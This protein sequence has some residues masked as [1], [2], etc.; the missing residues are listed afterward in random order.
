MQPIQLI[1]L[2]HSAF[3]T[4]FLMT[5]VA[6]FLSQ[7]GLSANYRCASSVEELETALLEGTADVAQSAVGVSMRQ[8]DKNPTV[9][10]PI[11]HFAQI[12]QRDGF[13][14]AAAV[15]SHAEFSWKGLENKRIIAD[16]LFQPMATLKYVLNQRGVDVSKIAFINAGDIE[17]SQAA[18]LDGKAEFIHLQGPYPQQ[19]MANGKAIIVASVG[20]ALGNIAYSSLCATKTW[21][22]SPM[23]TKFIHA[24]KAALA[25]VQQ[26]DASQLA[27]Q[28]TGQFPSI[29]PEILSETILAYKKLGS[30]SEDI[31]ISEGAFESANDVFLFS[32][33]ISKRID[34]QRVVSTVL[35]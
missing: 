24:Y 22:A 10:N 25:Y 6:D 9:I 26:A 28:L 19:L 1:S 35:C 20:E 30:W 33:D 17:Q 21:L 3:Y 34:Y 15:S 5:F 8:L 11:L 23:A 16:H 2:R 7:Q 32:G 27:V 18:F 31:C 12:N 14:I 13:F 29:K 4:P